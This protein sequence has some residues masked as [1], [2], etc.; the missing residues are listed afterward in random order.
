MSN[1][2]DFEGILKTDSSFQH[3]TSNCRI[4]NFNEF[5][6][7]YTDLSVLLKHCHKVQ[8]EQVITLQMVHQL[9]IKNL[10]VA[11]QILSRPCKAKLLLE[12]NSLC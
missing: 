12:T 4:K 6:R 2:S 7:E 1:I 8:G 11:G 5:E 10:K 9:K 3:F